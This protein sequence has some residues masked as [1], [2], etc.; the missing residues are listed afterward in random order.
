[1]LSQVFIIISG[2]CS[3][4]GTFQPPLRAI[5]KSYPLR[6]MNNRH[7]R[8]TEDLVRCTVHHHCYWRYGDTT[9]VSKGPVLLC[10][11]LALLRSIHRFGDMSCVF[12]WCLKWIR[13]VT[14][15]LLLDRLPHSFAP[16]GVPWDKGRSRQLLIFKYVYTDPEQELHKAG[17]LAI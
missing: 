10:L 13:R 12:L 9:G 7:I 8:V 5:M 16:N 14:W 1:M 2:L 6:F 4:S 15:R 3:I 11:N 17:W